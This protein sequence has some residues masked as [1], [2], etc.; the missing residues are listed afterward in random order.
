MKKDILIIQDMNRGCFR[1]VVKDK[2]GFAYIVKS[3]LTL[4]E[5]PGYILE[6]LDLYLKGIIDVSTITGV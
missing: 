3:N 6:W 5:L 4:G 2:T 1:L